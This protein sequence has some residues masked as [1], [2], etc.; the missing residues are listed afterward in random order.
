[1]PRRGR[2]RQPCGPAAAPGPASR[3]GGPGS[4]P[5]RRSD[6][7]GRSGAWGSARTGM[8]ASR[9]MEASAVRTGLSTSPTAPAGTGRLRR[10]LVVGLAVLACAVPAASAAAVTAPGAAR[11]A[12]PAAAQADT[13]VLVDVRAA[14][15]RGYDRV[16]FEFTG[17]GPTSFSTRYVDRLVADASG[18]RLA[19]GG[20]AILA[21]TMQGVDAHTAAGAVPVPGRLAFALKNVT[22]TVRSGDF[23]AVVSYGIGLQKRTHV[24]T[25]RL[26]DPARVV[27]DIDTPFT[28][29]SRKVWF[30]DDAKVDAGVT[31]P[32]TPVLR[33]VLT[34]SPGAGVMDR[35]YAGPTQAEKAAGLRLVT[36]RTTEWYGLRIADGIARVQLKWRCGDGSAV[37]TVADEIF[38]TLRQFATVDHVKIYGPDGTT[39][40]PTGHRDSI[41][42]CLEP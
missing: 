4:A 11:A 23:E 27:V 41:P 16:V 19:I 15:H 9:P 33:R 5:V 3:D 39:E 37:A 26:S 35:L 25:F 22:S 24:T 30:V 36:S 18:I 17:D 20:R 8:H 13:P 2:P 1:M 28:T 42:E 6:D 14:H 31:P 29:V 12:G 7:G 40:H 38:P 21:V 32:V 10:R 34:G